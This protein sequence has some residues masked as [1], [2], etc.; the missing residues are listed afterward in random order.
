MKELIAK[1]EEKY[2]AIAYLST[3]S[4]DTVLEPVITEKPY[5]ENKK[6]QTYLDSK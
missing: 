1:L 6:I 2:K 4:D 3:K 5:Q